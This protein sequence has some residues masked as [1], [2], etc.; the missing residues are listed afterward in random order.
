ML[1]N[2]VSPRAR[3][4]GVSSM[5]LARLETELFDTGLSQLSLWS[6][7]TAHR[8]YRSKGWVDAGDAVTED[9]TVSYPMRKRAPE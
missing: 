4:G 2:Y 3:F 7:Q 9:G 6:T 8:F 5:L 1:L